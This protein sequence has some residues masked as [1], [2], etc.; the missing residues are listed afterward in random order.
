MSLS[1]DRYARVSN[2]SA[3]VATLTRSATH[4]ASRSPQ[5]VTPAR[6]LEYEVQIESAAK[7]TS[8][9]IAS[10]AQELRAI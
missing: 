2:R 5:I 4:R 3:S 9:T 6:G 8:L 10:T 1:G 7:V